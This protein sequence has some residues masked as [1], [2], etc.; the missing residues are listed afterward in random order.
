MASSVFRLAVLSNSRHH[1][2]YAVSYRSFLIA[3][4]HGASIDSNGWLTP[5]VN[6]NSFAGE[7]SNSPESESFVLMMESA[8]RD[9]VD[10]GKKGAN[11]AGSRIHKFASTGTSIIVSLVAVIMGAILL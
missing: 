6:P 3:G 2:P 4:S 9:W 11:S 1:V 10:D 7:G 5:V 8:Y